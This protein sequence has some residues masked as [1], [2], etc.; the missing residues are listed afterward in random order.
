MHFFS[1]AFKI[2][3]A[4]LLI[5]L[6]SCAKSL[7]IKDPIDHQTGLTKNDFDKAIVKNFKKAQQEKSSEEKINEAPIPN[8]SRLIIAP[9][10]PNSVTSKTVSFAVTDQ[11]PLKDVLI[12]L[13]R[14]AKIDVDLDPA[15]SGG[16]VINAKNRPLSEVIDRIATLGSLRY[17][18][19]NG[20]LHFE[21]DTPYTHN[22]SVDYLAEGSNLWTEVQTNITSILSNSAGNTASNLA[23]TTS[24]ANNSEGNTTISAP[25]NS[26]AKSSLAINKSAGI[27]SVFATKKEHEEIAQYLSK[28]EENASAQVLIEAKV[29]EVQLSDSY[30]TGVTWGFSDSNIKGGTNSAKIN[31][32]YTAGSTSPLDVSIGVLIGKSLSA[33]ISALEKF[34]TTRTLSSPRI[35][36]INNQKAILNFTDKL[37]YFTINNNQNTSTT[38]AAASV[39][40]QTLTSTKQEENVGVELNI[41][42]SINLKT[43]EVTLNIKPK[44]TVKSGEA[45]D[46][47]SPIDQNGKVIFQNVV[48]IVQTREINTIAKLQSG[49]IIV[50]GGL[51]KESTNNTDSGVP[52]LQRIPILGN[53]FK[54]V[55]KSS[56]IVETVI[57]IK[58]TIVN[59]GSAV[60]KVDREL[61]EKFDTNKRKFF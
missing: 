48:P 9:P 12:E 47:A 40:T 38:S 5:A 55:D 59:S 53:L 18:Y 60:N 17:S 16:I 30:K 24:I 10:P 23:N 25:T 27:L 1:K 15:I 39:N 37:V 61:Q 29:V 43:S 3:F 33:S 31:G 41:T 52:F 34:G 57:F 56:G 49:N 13:G 42:P 51:M 46:P 20:I 7:T 26:L 58:A 6:F 22:Y 4:L 54:S 14:V 35:H 44:I 45:I 8:T 32:G 28:V 50:I 11:V 2:I 19:D 36:A 21:R